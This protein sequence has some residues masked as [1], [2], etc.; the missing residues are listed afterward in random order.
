M[1]VQ[2]RLDRTDGLANRTSAEAP[3]SEWAGP[4]FA[5][6]RKLGERTGDTVSHRRH[7]AAHLEF[8]VGS[9]ATTCGQRR[10]LHRVPGRAEGMGS[11]VCDSSGLLGG[12]SGSYGG[13]C[14]CSARGGTRCSTS[15]PHR[16]TNVELTHSE[17]TSLIDSGA[18][19]G[20]GR[21]R[22]L[23]DGNNMLSAVGR[24]R[25]NDAPIVKGQ[26]LR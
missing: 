2:Q 10:C 6:G 13:W 15:A 9:A 11:H 22:V 23:V 19:S 1:A 16:V 25:R 26:G 3:G 7:L 4:V 12:V 14:R 20:V 17:R 18:H 8:D 21:H 24:P 5:E